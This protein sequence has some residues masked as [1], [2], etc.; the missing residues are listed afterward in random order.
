MKKIVKIIVT[1]TVVVITSLIIKAYHTEPTSSPRSPQNCPVSEVVEVSKTYTPPI[2]EKPLVDEEM[3]KISTQIEEIIEPTTEE[4]S[5]PQPTENIEPTNTPTTPIQ[6]ATKPTTLT[7]KEPPTSQM[8]DTRIVDGQK[9]S[10]FL[11]FD[12]VEDK[13]ENECIYVEGMYENGN[14]IGIMDGGTMVGSDGDINKLVGIM[15]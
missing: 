9:Q 2:E 15:D 11:G 10:Y 12:W 4:S 5:T 1:A 7:P 3:S 6:A 13:G 8:G 14:K